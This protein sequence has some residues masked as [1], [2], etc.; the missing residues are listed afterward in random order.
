MEPTP[1]PP[2]LFPFS[3]CFQN[4]IS[5]EGLLFQPGVMNEKA[6]TDNKKIS[7]VT[8]CRGGRQ[9]EKVSTGDSQ[10]RET[11]LGDNITIYIYSTK[12]ES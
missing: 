5:Q 12:S 8:D 1:V 7:G 9:D 6:L 11:S 4:S 3:L 10:G 2:A